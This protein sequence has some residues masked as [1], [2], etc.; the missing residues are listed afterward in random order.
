MPMSSHASQG[1]TPRLPASRTRAAAAAAE[2]ATEAEVGRM[3]RL[4]VERDARTVVVGRG[5][6]PG[7]ARAVAEFIRHW[8]NPARTVLGTV[9]WPE[10]AASWLRQARQFTEPD[11]DLWIMAGPPA[12]WAQ[13]T[14]RLLW[15]TPWRPARTLAFAS[16]GA[17]PAIGLV[18]AA[19]LEGLAGATAGGRTWVVQA[20]QLRATD[21]GGG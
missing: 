10:E 17:G 6:T 3:L 12:G 19:N 5:R 21:T 13:M 1:P 11:P 2:A 8:E 16:V 4:A 18:G 14:R 7:A 20:G 9:T 15:S